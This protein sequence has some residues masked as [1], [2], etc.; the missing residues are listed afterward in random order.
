MVWTEG[1]EPRP[2]NYEF[3]RDFDL[4]VDY[5]TENIDETRQTARTEGRRSTGE[6]VGFS[7]DFTIIWRPL[8]NRTLKEMVSSGLPVN[9]PD[10][11][12]SCQ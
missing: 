11:E 5:P 6:F 12:T 4:E 8:T 1:F 9:R 10:L 2:R 7:S 3:F